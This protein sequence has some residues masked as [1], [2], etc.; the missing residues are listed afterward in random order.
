MRRTAKQ[1]MNGNV[2]PE[3]LFQRQPVQ[4]AE[5]SG[6]RWPVEAFL[7]QKRY[8]STPEK[9]RLWRRFNFKQ[10]EVSIQNSRN[11]L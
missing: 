7:K 4:I 9:T 6:S 1:P 8:S 2:R 10:K 5:K 3:T 11:R